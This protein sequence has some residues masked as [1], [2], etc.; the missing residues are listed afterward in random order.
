M[1]TQILGPQYRLDGAKQA[2][3]QELDKDAFLK[4]MLLQMR[5]QDPLNPMDN[6][7]MLSQMAQFSSLEQM[8]NLNQTMAAGQATTEFLNATPLIGTEVAVYDSSSDPESP[9]FFKSKVT[10][11]SYSPQG[12]ILHLEDGGMTTVQQIFR[13]SDSEGN[14]KQS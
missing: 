8:S 2:P 6:Q 9:Q 3:K 13:L 11:I 12:A 7:A 1:E 10:S 14:E 4:L 5:H